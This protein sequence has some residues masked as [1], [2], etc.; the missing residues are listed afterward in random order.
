[1]LFWDVGTRL[2]RGTD[3]GVS[4]D[5]PMS[6]ISQVGPAVLVPFVPTSGYAPPY[7]APA[8]VQLLTATVEVHTTQNNAGRLLSE[9]PLR[10]SLPPFFPL[11]RPC[12]ISCE[13]DIP[14]LGFSYAP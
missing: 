4:Y 3:A 11:S 13:R 1:M 6:G 5:V 10:L 2:V 14:S 7:P 8:Q 9:G 12:R